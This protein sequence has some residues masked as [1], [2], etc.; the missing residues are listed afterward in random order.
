MWR[1]DTVCVTKSARLK[2]SYCL[3]HLQRQCFSL[4][5]WNLHESYRICN[6]LPLHIMYVLEIL[7]QFRYGQTHSYIDMVHKLHSVWLRNENSL[8]RFVTKLC[9]KIFRMSDMVF[10]RSVVMTLLQHAMQLLQK[11]QQIPTTHLCIPM[12]IPPFKK[13]T[14]SLLKNSMMI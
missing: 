13:D 11:Q 5:S 1:I 4:S 9:C 14:L 2:T 8:Y 3:L 12:I 10:S 7:V 6:I